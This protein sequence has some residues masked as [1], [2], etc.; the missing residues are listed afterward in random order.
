MG[1]C[2]SKCFKKKE[3]SL[4][5]IIQIKSSSGNLEAA[6][7][8]QNIEKNEV[9]VVNREE[10]LRSENSIMS[11]EIKDNKVEN[12]FKSRVKLIRKR[13]LIGIS[14]STTSNSPIMRNSTKM[15]ITKS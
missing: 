3:N 12:I 8:N 7:D 6:Q 13:R 1:E 9:L 11:E 4:D 5:N 14:T 2:C 10:I 15:N